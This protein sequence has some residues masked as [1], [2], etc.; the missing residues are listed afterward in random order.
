MRGNQLLELTR[1]GEPQFA[2]QL[3]RSRNKSDSRVQT[4]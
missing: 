2:D 1:V 4:V 3:L